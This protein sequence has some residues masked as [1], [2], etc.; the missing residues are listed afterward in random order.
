MAATSSGTVT[1]ALIATASP[2]AAAMVATTSSAWGALSR[3][4]TTTRYPF[5]ASNNAVAAPIPR[6]APVI[7]A[8]RTIVVTSSPG[9]IERTP[10][11]DAPGLPVRSNPSILRRLGAEPA[12]RDHFLWRVESNGVS[13][14][15]KQITVKRTL[16]AAERK[17]R[18]RRRHAEIDA[19][20]PGLDTLAE[21]ASRRAGLREKGGRV[22]VSAA[23]CQGDRRVQV[24]GAHHAHHRAKNLL[25]A[26]EHLRR[27]IVEDG[28]PDEAAARPVG[29]SLAAAVEAKPGSFLTP[30]SMAARIRFSSFRFT[31]GPSV[32]VSSRPSPSLSSPAERRKASTTA[33]CRTRSPTATSTLPARQRCPA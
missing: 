27:H 19:E 24:R 10:V 18:H 33:S 9:E 22:A 14:L 16:P 23:V 32:S 5:L 13:T 17:E 25:P 21:G 2:P 8:T 1:S 28:R 31:T 6:L 11:A 30:R 3:W 29:D 7:R 26:D 15:G 4:L 12:F 20:H